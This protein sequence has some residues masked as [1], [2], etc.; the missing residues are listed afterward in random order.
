MGTRQDADLDLELPD[1]LGAPAVRPQLLVDDRA[2]ELVLE[3]GVPLGADILG[4][5][6]ACRRDE[7]LLRL[8]LQVVEALL[9]LRLVGVVQLRA[10]ATR[11]ELVDR[12][13]LG[14]I[15][16]R[17]GPLELRLAGGPAELLL[18]LAELHD[19]LLGEGQR[20]DELVL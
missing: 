1:V 9:A 6:R 19:A 18:G 20:L 10:D 3:H 17:W 4:G 5:D 16:D 7:L 13:E 8:V 12:A 11:E 15:P 2:A 14:L